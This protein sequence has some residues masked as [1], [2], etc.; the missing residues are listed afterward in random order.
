[1]P[2]SLAILTTSVA[3]FPSLTAPFPGEKQDKHTDLYQHGIFIVFLNAV[4]NI[5]VL[6]DQE[7]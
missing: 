6:P 3:L 1:M 5:M 2:L 4:L 7:Y